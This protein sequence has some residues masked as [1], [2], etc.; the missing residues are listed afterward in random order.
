[1][2]SLIEIPAIPTE[3]IQFLKHLS[4]GSGFIISGIAFFLGP[5]NYVK[6]LFH[7]DRIHITISSYLVT[8]A[9]GMYAAMFGV[10][11]YFTIIIAILQ[12]ASMCWFIWVV[13]PKAKTLRTGYARRRTADSWVVTILQALGLRIK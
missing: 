2:L 12:I 11:F 9:L 8:T 3:P 7:K 13:W 10:G 4:Y 1:M 6:G 5:V